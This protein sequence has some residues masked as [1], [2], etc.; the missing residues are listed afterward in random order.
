MNYQGLSYGSYLREDDWWALGKGGWTV[1]VR[2][3][4]GGVGRA[5]PSLEDGKAV[6]DRP[7]KQVWPKE[8]EGWP[9]GRSESRK[10]AVMFARWL[11]KNGVSD[12]KIVLV[13]IG[14]DEKFSKER[15]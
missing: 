1:F 9:E 13:R 2:T 10:A 3:E 6:R 4:N 5:C 8:D 12:G 15:R 11:L 14:P 7:W